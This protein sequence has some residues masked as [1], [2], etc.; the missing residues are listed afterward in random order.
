[1]VDNTDIWAAEGEEEGGGWGD[2]AMEPLKFFSVE[3]RAPSSPC[4]EP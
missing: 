2:E 3:P 4:W 1:M